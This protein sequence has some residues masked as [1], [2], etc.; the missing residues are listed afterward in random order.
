MNQENG[1]KKVGDVKPLELVDGLK[2][3]RNV[4]VSTSGIG[5][6]VQKSGIRFRYDLV[7]KEQF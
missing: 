5:H 4:F 7:S 3:V 1:R 6:D 2:H